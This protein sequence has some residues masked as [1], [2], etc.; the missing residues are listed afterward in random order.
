MQL[1]NKCSYAQS[2]PYDSL[3]LKPRRLALAVDLI[4]IIIIFDRKLILDNV[5][6]EILPVWRVST[7]VWNQF[8]WY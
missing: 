4:I 7:E 5:L 2:L 6:N 3:E 1:M 8:I